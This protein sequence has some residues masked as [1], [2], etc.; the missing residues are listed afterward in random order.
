MNLRSNNL[1]SLLPL[2]AV[3]FQQALVVRHLVTH[4]VFRHNAEHAADRSGAPHALDN[5][6][7]NL[8]ADV[9]RT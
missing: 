4:Q 8:L 1:T 5:T 2:E 9:I 6:L 7:D 3:L